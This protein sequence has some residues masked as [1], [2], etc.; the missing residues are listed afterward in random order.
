MRFGGLRTRTAVIFV[1]VSVISSATATGLLY[2][3]SRNF[4][5]QRTQ[6][7]V[8]ESFRD[9]V[10]ALARELDVPPGQDELRRFAQSVVPAVRNGVVITR[11][12]GLTAASDDRADRSRVTADLRAAVTRHA[13][14]SWQRVQYGD[15]PWFVVGAPVT[16]EKSGRSS[17][18]EVYAIVNLFPEEED[19]GR[20][21]R[22]AGNG[23]L[24]VALAAVALALLAARAV[25][26]PV[27]DLS[28]AA[29][30]LAAGDLAGRATVRGSDELTELTHT[31]NE[32]AA[33]LETSVGELRDQ[34]A[35]ARRFVADVSHE[36]RTPLAAM[37]MVAEV[38]DED[39][40]MM[41]PDSA[42]AAR[43]VSTEVAKLTRLVEDLI[44]ISR[45]DAGAAVLNPADVDVADSIRATIAAR[46]WRDLHLDLPPGVR[47]RLD[48]RRL[49]VI[50]ANLIGNALRHGAAPVT[51]RLRDIGAELEIE[52]ADRGPGIDPAAIQHVFDRF[53]KADAARTRSDG[54][55]LGLAI[56]QENAALHD[57]RI[58]VENR[59]GAV[60]TLRLPKSRAAE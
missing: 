2:R 7:A 27:R 45:F 28:R 34:E 21:L 42:R 4:V 11:Y 39:A 6:D 36:L 57:G 51:V 9:R 16:F 24:L 18:L 55:G 1:L 14:L 54:S 56:A 8:M 49:D 26:Q 23:M 47:T 32:T 5:L 38:L 29:R 10:S 37:A 58:S 17:G 12:G 3:Q 20:L 48:R 44:E 33:A 43:T 15:R 41:P 22:D 35:R 59:Q 25:L 13:A 31:F 30:R 19:I 50:V 52:V 60:F 40:A 46:G 53:Y